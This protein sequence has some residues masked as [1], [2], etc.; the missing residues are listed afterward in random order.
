M[1]AEAKRIVQ[2]HKLLSRVQKED[3]LF[4]RK[5]FVSHYLNIPYHIIED[6]TLYPRTL[7]EELFAASTYLIRN[8]ELAPYK[9]GD[10]EDKLIADIDNGKL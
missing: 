8:F 4:I 9:Q 2:T 10:L 1:Q 5:V 3:P 7:I 6:R